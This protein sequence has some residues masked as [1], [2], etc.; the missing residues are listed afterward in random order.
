MDNNDA[1][2]SARQQVTEL[3]NQMLEDVRAKAE[4]LGLQLTKGETKEPAPKQKRRRRT[5]EQIAADNAQE[6][7]NLAA[8]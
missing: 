3:E 8:E 7:T 2:K 5:K 6:T 1:L 4:L